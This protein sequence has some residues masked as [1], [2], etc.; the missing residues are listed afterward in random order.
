MLTRVL[1][2]PNFASLPSRDAMLRRLTQRP[3]SDRGMR[4]P[5][6]TLQNVHPTALARQDAN[7]KDFVDEVKAAIATHKVVVVGMGWNPSVGRV[8]RHLTTRGT[9]YHYIGHGNYITGWRRRLAL[10]LWAGWPTFPMVFVNG[11]LVGGGT[12]LIALDGAGELAKLL[13]SQR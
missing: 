5:M 13:E 6:Q 4:P 10:K 1:R 11:S 3:R 2:P 9:A 12:D 7:H 8:R